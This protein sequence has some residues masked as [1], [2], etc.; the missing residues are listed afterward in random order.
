MKSNNINIF[1]LLVLI[2]SLTFFS[3]SKKSDEVY[4]SSSTICD[5]V[6]KIDLLI[7]DILSKKCIYSLVRD[8]TVR[9]N[10]LMSNKF[11]KPGA[12]YI[13][14]NSIPILSVEKDSIVN[15]NASQI[16]ISD[17]HFNYHTSYANL[18]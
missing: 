10:Y 6:N 11:I 16:Y 15:K 1:L 13:G 12:K 4:K 18:K 3:C 9:F 7:R 8:D 17:A 14:Y 2:F 5:T